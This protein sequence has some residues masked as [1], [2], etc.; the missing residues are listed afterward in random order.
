MLRAAFICV[1]ISLYV[2]IVGP[3][4]LLYR[5]HKKRGFPLLGGD[6]GRYVLRQ[7]RGCA[8][9]SQRAGA[10][11]FANLHMLPPTTPVQQM[12]QRWYAYSA[13]DRD[14]SE[15]LTLQI[16]HRG[17]GIYSCALHSGRSFQSRF[18][19]C[20]LEKATEALRDG[21]SFSIYPEGSRNSDSRLQEFKKGTAVMAIKARC[22]D[23]ADRVFRCPSHH[24]KA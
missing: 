2:L 9:S 13:L 22:A 5:H 17:P 19:D 21:Q 20:H 23:C 15:A 10:Y 18:R 3:P 12:H 16:P 4:L 8:C 6:Q 11:T 24:A 7:L 1:S 14:S